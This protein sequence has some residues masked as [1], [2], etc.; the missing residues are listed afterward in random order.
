MRRILMVTVRV[1]LHLTSTIFELKSAFVSKRQN[2]R[3]TVMV[4]GLLVRKVF[5]RYF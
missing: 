2:G 3:F 1:V 4:W 5:L